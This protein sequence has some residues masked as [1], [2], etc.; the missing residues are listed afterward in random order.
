MYFFTNADNDFVCFK[1]DSGVIRV[2]QLL[3]I[4]TIG[5]SSFILYLCVYFLNKSIVKVK[6]LADSNH[7]RLERKD[8]IESNILKQIV[9][10]EK[11]VGEVVCKH[12]NLDVFKDIF[13]NI[14]KS[15]HR[16]ADILRIRLGKLNE[17][18]LL[19]NKNKD[20]NDENIN[21]LDG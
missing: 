11:L 17:N 21:L 3:L 14:E 7:L 19:F 4:L 5:C 18:I 8:E 15:N 6:R 2:Y 1:I 13:C 10:L 20:N 12:E 16:I 9:F